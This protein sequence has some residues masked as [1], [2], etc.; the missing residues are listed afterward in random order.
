MD[1]CLN[2]H[3]CIYIQQ[4]QS[5]TDTGLNTMNE[6]RSRCMRCCTCTCKHKYIMNI[7][8]YICIYII[9]VYTFQRLLGLLLHRIL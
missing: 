6:P 3:M 4:T 5:R 7:Y 1:T 8:M 9:L 2:L